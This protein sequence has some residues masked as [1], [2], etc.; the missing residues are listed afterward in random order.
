MP[1]IS[2]CPKCQGQV[3]IPAGIDAAAAVRCPLCDAEYALSEALLLAPPELIPVLATVKEPD[4]E[5]AALPSEE[6]NEAAAV[7]QGAPLAVG[8][9][10]RRRQ[11]SWLART[12]GIVIFGL[13]GGVVGLYGLAL[14]LGP[15]YHKQGF[16]ERI[17]ID[18]LV[19]FPLPGMAWLT[20]PAEKADKSPAKPAAEKP[21]EPDSTP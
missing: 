5:A 4:A 1:S 10:L 11:T 9:P 6:I 18:G 7:A 21:V 15:R 20:T 16:P 13:A 3:S 19:D 12:L 14:F 2:N 17:H 8:A